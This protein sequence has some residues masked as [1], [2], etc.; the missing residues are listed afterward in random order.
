M[1]GDD[2]I[3]GTA[4]NHTVRARQRLMNW[5]RIWKVERKG[6]AL[7]EF[8]LVLPVFLLLIFG[9]LEMGRAVMVK[10]LLDDAARAGCRVAS[11]QGATQNDVVSVVNQALTKAGISGHDVTVTPTPPSSADH[12][13]PVSVTISV[14][15][16]EVAW[17]PSPRFMG[18]KSLTGVCIMPAVRDAGDD[19][20]D[21]GDP[22]SKKND[23][24]SKKNDP[25]SKKNKKNK[26]NKK[27]KKKK[28][29]KKKSSS[30]DDD[31][32]GGSDDDD[33]D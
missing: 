14:P 33:D 6:A 5:L 15:H 22:P 31:D 18:G 28:K 17:M 30:D 16:S 4:G 2:R 21:V 25:P 19:N 20:G 3:S 13:E 10:H 1:S 26:K 8:A 29:K 9:G 7:V 32:G 24:P 27:S 11:M 23:P 12:L